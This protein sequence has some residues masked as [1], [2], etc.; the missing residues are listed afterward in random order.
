MDLAG[1]GSGHE[2]GTR[3]AGPRPLEEIRCF[4]PRDRH[5]D[6][7]RKYDFSG[8]PRQREPR[9]CFVGGGGRGSCSAPSAH[10]CLSGRSTSEQPVGKALG[11][12][13]RF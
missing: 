10:S 1:M 4:L 9:A 7:R 13:N 11:S 12:A 2:L 6:R 3:G 8:S 5:V